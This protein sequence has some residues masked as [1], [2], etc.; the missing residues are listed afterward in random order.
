M[1]DTP[2]H[3]QGYLSHDL[4]CSFCGHPMHTYLPCSETC[5]CGSHEPP[6]AVA[7]VAA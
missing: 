2:D 3:Q 5:D 1:W 6:G 7:L 4:P